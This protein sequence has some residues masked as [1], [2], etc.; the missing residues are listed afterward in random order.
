MDTLIQLIFE[1]WLYSRNIKRKTKRKKKSKEILLKYS[2]H[3]KKMLSF[4]EGCVI[5]IVKSC[6]K[7]WEFY[8]SNSC[9]SGLKR[10]RLLLL[11]GKIK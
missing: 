4:G 11:F 3:L 7:C 9:I 10:Q 6:M 2:Q 8:R 1:L 5:L